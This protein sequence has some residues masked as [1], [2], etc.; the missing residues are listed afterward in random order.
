MVY[1]TDVD[2]T[3]LD[4]ALAA[5][6]KLNEADY[7][8]ETWHATKNFYDGAV[9]MKDGTYPQNAVTVAA[10][11]L[12]DSMG[13]LAPAPKAEGTDTPAAKK[14][15]FKLPD[16][17]SIRVDKGIVAAAVAGVVGTAAGVTAGIIAVLKNKK[18]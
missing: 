7:T 3:A 11:K 12:T 6:E 9:A 14:P 13:E 1:Y 5:F 2:F 16:L 18:K 8:A 15:L 4:E 17:K 10:W